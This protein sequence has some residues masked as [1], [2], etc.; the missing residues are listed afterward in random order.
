M[1]DSAAKPVPSEA[2]APLTADAR[3]RMCS[4]SLLCI[5]HHEVNTGAGQLSRIPN[6]ATRLGVEGRAVENYLTRFT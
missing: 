2:A 5:G 3:V 4:A 6:L 1:N